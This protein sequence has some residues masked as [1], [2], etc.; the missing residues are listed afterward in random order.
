MAEDFFREVEGG[1]LEKELKFRVGA[2]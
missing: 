2:A 1:V